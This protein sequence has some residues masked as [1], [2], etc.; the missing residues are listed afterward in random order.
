MKIRK[1]TLNNI[2]NRT[3]Q[4]L[5]GEMGH[6]VD[7]INWS[8]LQVGD[9]VD[10]DSEYNSYPRTRITRK[11]DDVSLESSLP[12]GPG[13][14]GYQLDRGETEEFVFSIQDVDPKSFMKYAMAENRRAESALKRLI[15]EYSRA[16]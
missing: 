1:S 14:I 8:T 13:F 2:I 10:V 11:I 6:G 16:P 4:L 7:M 15:K 9:L 12:A 3:S 5:E